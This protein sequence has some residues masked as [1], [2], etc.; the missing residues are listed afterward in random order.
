[1]WGLPISKGIIDFG[2]SN[3]TN[4]DLSQTWECRAICSSREG[5]IKQFRLESDM[6]CGGPTISKGIIDF[7]GIQSNKFRFESSSKCSALPTND[8]NEI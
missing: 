6:K 7:G 5:E 1:M 4:S 2:E 3:Q 8:C